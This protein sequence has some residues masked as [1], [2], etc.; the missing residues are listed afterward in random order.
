MAFMFWY[1]GKLLAD[2][3]LSVGDYFIIYMA[4]M[5]GGQAAGFAFGY[6]AGTFQTPP[7]PL[8]SMLVHPSY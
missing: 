1:G 4:A 8:S 3:E 7:P 6:F 5:F 2:G